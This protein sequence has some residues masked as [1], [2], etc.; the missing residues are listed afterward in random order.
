MIKLAQGEGQSRRGGSLSE[1]PASHRRRPLSVLFLHRDAEAI[2]CSLRELEKGQFTVRSDFVL[3]L[4]QCT[5]QLRAQSYDV[6]IVE[7][8]S[9]SCK[10]PHFLQQLH[11]IAQQAPLIFLTAAS[12]RENIAELTAQEAFEHVEQQNLDQLSMAVRRV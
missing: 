1:R 11:Q 7:Y 10:G 3:N 2:D 8:P 4:A 9:P 6:I 12:E 5:E